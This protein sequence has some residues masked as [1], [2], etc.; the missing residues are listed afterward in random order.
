MHLLE[1]CLSMWLIDDSAGRCVLVSVWSIS[2]LFYSLLTTV[3]FSEDGF[4]AKP[5][6]YGSPCPLM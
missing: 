1:S 6:R 5:T 3:V 4:K 2:L